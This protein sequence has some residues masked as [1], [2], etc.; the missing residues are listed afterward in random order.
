MVN[1]NEQIYIILSVGGN[2]SYKLAKLYCIGQ[3]MVKW[4]DFQVGMQR[5]CI[6]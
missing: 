2:Q 6:A 1:V 5:E 3:G 4:Q